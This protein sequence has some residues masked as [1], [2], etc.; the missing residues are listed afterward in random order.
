M[1][2]ITTIAFILACLC[3]K[4]Q[5]LM[6]CPLTLTYPQDSTVLNYGLSSSGTTDWF[7]IGQF[8]PDQ[9][10]KEGFIYDKWI[11]YQSQVKPSGNLMTTFLATQNRYN[12]LVGT[13]ESHAWYCIYSYRGTT[14]KQ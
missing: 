11:P 8:A 2:F 6:T 13:V 7:L 4:A 9:N 10:A 12:S 3:V 14:K 1:K 5:D